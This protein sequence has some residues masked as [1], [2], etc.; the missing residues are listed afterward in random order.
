[1]SEKEKNLT[2]IFNKIVI[3]LKDL[4]P[5]AIHEYRDKNK[6]VIPF[7]YV[8]SNNER[9]TLNVDARINEKWILIKCLL[10]LAKNLPPV[11]NL[12]PILHR[13]LLQA[14]F[15]F[16]EVTYSLDEYGNIFVEVDMPHETDFVNFKSEFVSIV[17]GIEQF[18]KKIIPSIS[19]QIKRENTYKKSIYT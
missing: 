13:K 9:I 15:E 18:F 4:N 5:P 3:F 19:D 10:M 17:F 7:E 16:V 1:M 6:I 2:E 14:N 12:E 11:V 8:F